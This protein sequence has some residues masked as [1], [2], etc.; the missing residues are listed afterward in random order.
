[1]PLGACANPY[2]TQ[3]E[4]E[5]S[6]ATVKDLQGRVMVGQK[7][8]EELQEK[9]VKQTEE[10]RVRTDLA[11]SRENELAVLE[12]RLRAMTVRFPLS[13]LRSHAY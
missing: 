5:E 7:Y 3:V 8:A 13:A 1:M 6:K 11:T 9:L 2:L 12:N 4:H 10:V